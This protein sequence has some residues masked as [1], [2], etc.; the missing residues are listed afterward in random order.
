MSWLNGKKMKLVVIRRKLICL[1]YF[2]LVLLAVTSLS[3][4]QVNNLV[5]NPSFEEDEPVLHDDASGLRGWA[6]WPCHGKG[7]NAEIVEAVSIDGNRSLRVDPIGTTM[8]N[9][10]V[11]YHAFPAEVSMKYTVSFWAKAEEPRPFGAQF[12]ASDNSVSWGYTDFQL[13]T[14][15]AEYSFTAEALSA[16]AKLEL[17]CAGFEVTFWLDFV[18]IYEGDYVAG[19]NPIL[20]LKA[21]VPNPVDGALLEQTWVTFGW[22]AGNLA[23][24]HDVYFGENF[25]DVNNGTHESETFRG[26]QGLDAL[27]FV[28]GFPEYAYPDGL[29]YGA[30]YYWRIDEVNETEPN[31]PWIGDVWSFM[32][33]PKTA[34]DPVPPDGATFL[35]P[36]VELSW[37]AGFGAQLHTLYLGEDF[38]DVNTATDGIA[39]DVTKYTPSSIQLAKTYYWRIDES[40]GLETTKGKVWSFSIADYIIVDNFE[41]YDDDMDAGTTIW[42]TWIDG[43]YVWTSGSMVGYINPPFAETII[44]YSGSQAMP[45]TYDND[46]TLFEGEEDEVTGVPYYSETQRTWEE[47]QDWT[48]R[49]VEVLTMWFYGEPDNSA[50]LFYVGL[51]DSAGNRKDITHPNPTALT[52]NDWQQWHIP[53]ADFTDVDPTAIKIMYIGVGDPASNQPGGSGLVR[54]DDIEL[55]RSSEQ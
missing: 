13:T 10:I 31:S 24:S 43:V 28:A 54:I 22:L 37:S 49:D 40:T 18:Y 52:V 2:V 27:Y 11:F 53:L 17:F 7:S 3:H 44:V 20:P 6:T 45:L 47:P 55:H 29:V 33:P 35:Q 23:A 39:V 14:E 36:D 19:I 5:Q 41:D 42:E 25:D 50:D 38:Y 48:R 34:Y 9:F 1:T 51:E 32:V 30:T 46:G 8:A 12:K 21:S 4:A 16:E 15:W 26:N